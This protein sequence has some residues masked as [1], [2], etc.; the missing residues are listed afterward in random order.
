MKPLHRNDHFIC[1]DF[2]KVLNSFGMAGLGFIFGLALR[3]GQF[4][5]ICI[6]HF[7]NI[8]SLKAANHALM[9]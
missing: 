4:M 2:L 3:S 8:C 7:H 5:C 9:S 6:V 1:V